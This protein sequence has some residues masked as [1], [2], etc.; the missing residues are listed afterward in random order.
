MLIKIKIT[1]NTIDELP[2]IIT[3]KVYEGL[4]TT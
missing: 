1:D 3:H 2:Q 4:V